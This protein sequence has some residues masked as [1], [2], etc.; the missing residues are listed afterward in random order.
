[1]S[2]DTSASI[3]WPFCAK[4]SCKSTIHFNCTAIW[5]HECAHH[6]Y[7]QSWQAEYMQHFSKLDCITAICQSPPFVHCCP[8]LCCSIVEF[9]SAWI[10]PGWVPTFVWQEH[11]MNKCST[12]NMNL[13]ST[14]PL[15][16]NNKSWISS[17]MPI[18]RLHEL[19]KPAH[20]NKPPHIL[21]K[22]ML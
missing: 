12:A 21:N 16:Y 17:W 22:V 10:L 7:A 11:V 8:I 13:A 19:T 5:I 15:V 14:L 6:E 3:L 9:I 1:M 2:A 20:K 4:H 18:R